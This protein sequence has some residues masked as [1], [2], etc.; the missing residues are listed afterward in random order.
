MTGWWCWSSQA[1]DTPRGAVIT[2]SHGHLARSWLRGDERTLCAILAPTRRTD[3]RPT[4]YHRAHAMEWRGARARG[5]SSDVRAGRPAPD[6]RGLDP[7]AGGRFRGRPI[8]DQPG[9]GDQPAGVRVGPA[10]ARATGRRAWASVDSAWLGD[11]RGHRRYRRLADSV[12]S[13][14]RGDVWDDCRD[15]LRRGRQRDG[16]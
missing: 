14:I 11:P 2:T 6:L 5:V 13:R 10:V 3:V 8:G 7:P 15:R 4:Q 16:D 12:V 1:P 9:R